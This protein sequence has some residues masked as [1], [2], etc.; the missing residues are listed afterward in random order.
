MSNV[1]TGVAKAAV[2]DEADVDGDSETEVGELASTPPVGVT[3][4]TVIVIVV[5]GRVWVMVMT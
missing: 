3:D 1:K 5:G 4:D 2:E